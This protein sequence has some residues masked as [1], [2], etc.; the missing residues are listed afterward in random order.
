MKKLTILLLVLSLVVAGSGLCLADVTFSDSFNGGIGS[1][2]SEVFGK[3]KVEKIDDR[4]VLSV[5]PLGEG[6]VVY[7]F[8]Q[9]ASGKLEFTAKV[10]SYKLKIK[11][12]NPQGEQTVRVYIEDDGD[13]KVRPFK[14]GDFADKVE[15]SWAKYVIEWDQET[16]KLFV[17]VDGE[18]KLVC[19]EKTIRGGPLATVELFSN[20]PAKAYIDEVT[21]Y[22][23]K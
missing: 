19:K 17:K 22:E 12:R 21:F 3:A 20:N 7:N 14:D 1:V 13:L 4:E 16:L 9:N 11:F 5:A 6:G 10:E 23:Y 15:G 18:K 2:W 8:D